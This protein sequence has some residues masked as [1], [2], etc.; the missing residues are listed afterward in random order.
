MWIPGKRKKEELVFDIVLSI[1]DKTFVSPVSEVESTSTVPQTPRS[2]IRPADD[3]PVRRRPAATATTPV[4]APAPS[5]R[6]KKVVSSSAMD[7]DDKENGSENDVS[8]AVA[9]LK[10]EPAVPVV[11]ALTTRARRSTRVQQ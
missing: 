10:F 5:G 2:P 3:R 11:A 8:S 7:V 6:G 1:L 4:P 9:Q